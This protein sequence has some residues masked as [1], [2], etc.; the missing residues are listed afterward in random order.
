MK[1]V[2]TIS[3]ELHQK[4]SVEC[5]KRNVKKGDAAEEAVNLWLKTKPKKDEEK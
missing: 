1:T 2:I 3:N 5:A 4:F